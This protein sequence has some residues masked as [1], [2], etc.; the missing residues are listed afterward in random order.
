MATSDSEDFESADE[1]VEVEGD[2][3]ALR[4]AMKDKESDEHS[5][6]EDCDNKK[7]KDLV[8]L[9]RN[10]IETVE[11]QEDAPVCKKDAEAFDTHNNID[12]LDN[13]H[14]GAGSNVNISN[15]ACTKYE[16]KD[17]QRGGH[18]K[19]QQK[20]REPK[21]S[22]SVRKL[23]TKISSSV[24][25]TSSESESEKAKRDLLVSEKCEKTSDGAFADTCDETEGTS[26]QSPSCR[27]ENMEQDLGKL[28]VDS[29]E[30]DRAPVLENLPQPASEKVCGSNL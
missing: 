1:E 19:R 27:M 9:I 5:R 13:A 18:V 4:S 22:G 3:T 11:L 2:R 24:S 29:R 26:I 12:K 14:L 20:P 15:E 8:R 10:E 23:G 25:Y 16:T 7:E 21:S 28:S 30:H 17:R 6:K